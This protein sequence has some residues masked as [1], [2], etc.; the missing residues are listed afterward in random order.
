MM[1]T[2][3]CLH[4]QSLRLAEEYGEGEDAS[5]ESRTRLRGMVVDSL[6]AAFGREIVENQLTDVSHKSWIGDPL[7]HLGGGEYEF[8]LPYACVCLFNFICLYS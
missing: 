6:G 5:E 4:R 7:T 2:P 3:V 8:I 1:F